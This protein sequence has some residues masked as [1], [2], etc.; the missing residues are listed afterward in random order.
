M[1]HRQVLNLLDHSLSP[2]RA[3]YT[4]QHNLVRNFSTDGALQSSPRI[5]SAI[6]GRSKKQQQIRLHNRAIEARALGDLE[7]KYP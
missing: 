3:A 4:A 7:R 5:V 2:L 6:A 1:P